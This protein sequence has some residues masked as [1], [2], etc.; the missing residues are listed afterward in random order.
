M[1]L[2]DHLKGKE[3]SLCSVE[4]LSRL[5]LITRNQKN[6]DLFYYENADSKKLKIK[7]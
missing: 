4:L 2:P 5:T 7:K 1:L 3:N 6:Y